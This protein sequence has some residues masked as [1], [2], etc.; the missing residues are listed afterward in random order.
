MIS[1]SRKTNES[2]KVFAEL[3]VG[4]TFSTCFPDWCVG[5]GVKSKDGEAIKRSWPATQS[6]PYLLRISSFGL[7]LA[8]CS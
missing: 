4:L 1:G 5:E 3:E 8:K 7:N 2:V 6:R